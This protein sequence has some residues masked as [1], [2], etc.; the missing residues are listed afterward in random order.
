MSE[1]VSGAVGAEQPLSGL[2][3]DAIE[4]ASHLLG[5][6]PDTTYPP[7]R[8]LALAQH[9]RRTYA[10]ALYAR[11]ADDGSQPKSVAELI[12]ES[13]IEIKEAIVANDGSLEELIEASRLRE[14]KRLERLKFINLG[15]RERWRARKA[16]RAVMQSITPPIVLGAKAVE[17]TP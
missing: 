8:I 9:L 10:E 11:P 12:Y 1:G 4:Q 6:I 5:E 2:D 15:F 17:T 3:A 16:G 14:Q 7:Q 13:G